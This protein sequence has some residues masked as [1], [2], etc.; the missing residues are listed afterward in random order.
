[1]WTIHPVYCENV[2]IQHVTVKSIGP[3][4]D[5]LNPDSCRNVKVVGCSFST[6]DDCVAINSG[7]NE[8]GWRVARPCENILIHNCHMS[9]GHGAVAIGSGMSG[10][11]RNVYVHDCS[12]TGGDQGIRLKSMRG[13]G[14][15]V[16][17]I[18]FENIKMAGLRREAIVLN[19][20][21]GSS[22]VASRSVTPPLFRHIH[23]KNVNCD[24]AGA[25]LEI[26]GLPEQR[27][28]H[29]VLEHVH[30]N[31]TEGIR[32]QDVDDLSLSDVNGVVEKEPMLCCSNAQ[33]MT[34]ADVALELGKK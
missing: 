21:Y 8:D 6:G 11:V 26:R 32:C 23:I 12:F 7:M 1:M 14:G 15:I 4:T 13:R 3:N 17:N 10:G 20:F 9:E 24:S 16:E 33:C 34:M 2:L 30:L 22:T 5:G 28:Q 18:Y 25:A 29:V 27:I 31:T 19:M